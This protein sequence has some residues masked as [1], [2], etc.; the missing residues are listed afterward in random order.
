MAIFSWF[1]HFRKSHLTLE[2]VNDKIIDDTTF[3]KIMRSGS[4][5]G[6]LYQQYQG[7]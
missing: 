3:N 7:S 1:F 2:R 4:S 6:V 5:P